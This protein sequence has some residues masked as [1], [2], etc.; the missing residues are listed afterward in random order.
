MLSQAFQSILPSPG[1]LF[2]LLSSL[3]S[4][5]GRETAYSWELL[6]LPIYPAITFHVQQFALLPCLPPCF[7]HSPYLTLP[8]PVVTLMKAEKMRGK[9]LEVPSEETVDVAFV[10]GC[11][12]AGPR[13]RGSLPGE[14]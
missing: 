13:R 2:P 5:H 11:K 1:S 14:M 4:L 9:V 8:L 7:F 10:A 12:K 6:S 3:P